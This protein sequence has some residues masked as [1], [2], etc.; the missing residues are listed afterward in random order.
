MTLLD[1][2][3]PTP[4]FDLL[5]TLDVEEAKRRRVLP[6]MFKSPIIILIDLTYF[7]SLS[8]IHCFNDSGRRRGLAFGNMSRDTLTKIID[9]IDAYEVPNVC[10]SGGDALMNRF[11]WYAAEELT[12]LRHCGVSTILNGW[13]VDEK[14]AERIAGVFST[15]EVS[16][17][18]GIDETHDMIRGRVGSFDRALST[19]KWLIAGGV[20]VVVAFSAMRYNVHEFYTLVEKVAALGVKE[21]A[22]CEYLI[23]LGRAG[24][25]DD[26]ELH[27]EQRAFLLEQ[28]QKAQQDFSIK[29][30]LVDNA[31]TW[32]KQINDGVPNHQML[33]MPDGQVKL[34]PFLPFTFGNLHEQSVNTIWTQSLGGVFN[35]PQ[36]RAYAA[37]M[38]TAGNVQVQSYL[39][40]INPEVPFD[41]FWNE[42]DVC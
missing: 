13:M 34:C 24:L 7:C 40:Y 11:Y 4:V 18:G 5:N 35:N 37:G 42:A 6:T 29:I 25:R 16:I 28:R 30:A 27:A 32:L 21:I 9:Y 2:K 26:L 8:C 31:G 19:V 41:Q 20:N 10:L 1:S 22:T 3:K 38:L 33:I 39:P 12:R 17:D 14:I 15:V 23:P 36:F